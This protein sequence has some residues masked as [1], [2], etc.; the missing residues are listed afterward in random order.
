MVDTLSL[1]CKITFG[2]EV[3]EREKE[4]RETWNKKYDRLNY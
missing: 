4:K 1:W 2:D 3:R